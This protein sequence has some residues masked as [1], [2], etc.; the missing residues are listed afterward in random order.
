MFWKLKKSVVYFQ[1]SEKILF[2]KDIQDIRYHDIVCVDVFHKY[3]KKKK[4][5]N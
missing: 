4:S 3:K 1:P 5:A 2:C